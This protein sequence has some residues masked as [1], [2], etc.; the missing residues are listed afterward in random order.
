[1]ENAAS[2]DTKEQILNV[3]EQLI[4][5]YGYAGTTVRNIVSKAKVNLA[6]VH[7][8]FGSKEDLFRAVFSRIARPIVKEQLALMSAMQ[9]Q[10]QTPTI[11]AILA[12]FLTPPIAH[13]V[14]HQSLGMVRA[15]FM[16]RCWTEPEPVQSIAFQEFKLSR[17][18]YLEALQ[19]ALPTQPRQEL[20]W[21][22][23]MV[24]AVMI[25]VKTEAGKPNALLKSNRTEDIQDTVEKLV[26]FLAPGMQA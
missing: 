19:R 15:Q 18:A 16:G 17:D 13:I 22:I 21:K 9:D 5:E 12:A 2:V 4:A 10:G 26:R 25:R 1:M 3:A 24:I 11:E 20:E 7:Y 14:Q 6:A 23:D 8:H